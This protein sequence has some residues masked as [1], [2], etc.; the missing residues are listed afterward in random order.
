LA[1]WAFKAGGIQFRPLQRQASP[2][3]NRFHCLSRSRILQRLPAQNSNAVARQKQ[4]PAQS[5]SDRTTFYRSCEVFAPQNTPSAG[6]QIT[7][8]GYELTFHKLTTH[9]LF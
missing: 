5:T 3:R 6:H 8:S 4:I 9:N 7:L 1:A 2:L